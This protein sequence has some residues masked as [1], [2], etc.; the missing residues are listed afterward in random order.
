[1]GGRRPREA[2]HPESFPSRL[3]SRLHRVLQPSSPLA[4]HCHL[5]AARVEPP[6]VQMTTAWRREGCQDAIGARQVLRYLGCPQPI[7]RRMRGM[8]SPRA[9]DPGPLSAFSLARGPR[10]FKLLPGDAIDSEIPPGV[11]VGGMLHVM[12][13]KI[14]GPDVPS[15]DSSPTQRQKPCGMTPNISEDNQLR[16]SPDS[17]PAARHI[18][19]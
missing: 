15:C 8:A 7:A 12:V 14:K 17:R 6:G 4:A 5:G 1:M 10:S 2:E 13:P 11:A 18:V 9:S 3:S 16:R 19:P